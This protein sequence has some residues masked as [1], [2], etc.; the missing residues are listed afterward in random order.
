MGNFNA[1]VGNDYSAWP[2]VLGRHGIGNCNDN[3][4]HLL[5]LCSEAKLAI[6]NTFFQQKSSFKTT[7]MHPRSKHWHLLDYIIV[8]QCDVRDVVH[9][10]VMPSADCYTDHRLVRT[11]LNITVKMVKKD[12]LP[13]AKKLNDE[14]LADVRERFSL[15]LEADLRKPQDDDPV[16]NWSQLKAILQ[17]VT[18]KAVNPTETGL[19]RTIPQLRNC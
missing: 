10:R 13:R 5:E 9:T 15:L 12:G 1:R 19:M 2:G 7:W 18:A 4:R 16:S 3:G 11:K 14:R 6:T 17:G 8:R